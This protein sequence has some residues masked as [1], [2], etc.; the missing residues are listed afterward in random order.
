MTSSSESDPALGAPERRGARSVSPKAA[1]AV[2]API[3][4]QLL[5][6]TLSAPNSSARRRDSCGRSSSWASGGPAE[7]ALSTGASA[8][9][10]GAFVDGPRARISRGAS[11][12]LRSRCGP[13]SLAG[14]ARSPSTVPSSSL[15]ALGR[16]RHRRERFPS[17][18]RCPLSTRHRWPPSRPHYRPTSERQSRSAWKARRARRDRRRD[19]RA[20][21]DSFQEEVRI[22]SRAEQQLNSGRAEDAR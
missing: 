9:I 4:L 10:D 13:G 16:G 5:G 17:S 12:R 20:P 1:L 8:S 15:R 19:P 3:P 18:P 22:L 14:W 6:R 11:R 7:G 21:S 2:R